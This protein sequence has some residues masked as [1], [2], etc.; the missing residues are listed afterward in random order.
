MKIMKKKQ[1]YDLGPFHYMIA[2]HVDVL[3]A[4]IDVAQLNIRKLQTRNGRIEK[5]EEIVEA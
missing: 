3:Y 1:K 5:H 4:H 2:A